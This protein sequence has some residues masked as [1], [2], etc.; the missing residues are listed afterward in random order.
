MPS[1]FPFW[2]T[3]Q[4]HV[5]QFQKATGMKEHIWLVWIIYIGMF[6]SIALVFVLSPIIAWHAAFPRQPRPTNEDNSRALIISPNS[7]VQ[8]NNSNMSF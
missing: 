7:T 3:V 2:E 4:K 1:G 8:F 5:Y 6:I